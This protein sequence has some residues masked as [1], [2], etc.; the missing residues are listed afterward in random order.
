MVPAGNGRAPQ[1]VDVA[2]VGA[3]LAGLAAARELEAA[4][5]SV[6]V[7]EARDRVGGR[8]LN[9]PIGDGDVVEVGGQWAGPTQD[10]ILALARAVGVET[11]PTHTR[12][13]N[14]I[15]L[16]GELRRYTGTIPRVG[17]RALADVAQ[18]QL[19]ID[20]LARRVPVD[21]PWRTRSAAR[22]DAQTF[23]SWMR[24]NVYT[25]VGRELIRLAVEAVWAAEPEDVSLL[26]VLF[27][28]RS[29]GGF[30]RLLDTEGGAQQDRFVGG[31][32]AIATRTAD[33]I[34]GPVLLSSPVRRIEHGAGS[35]RVLADGGV[36]V[37]ARRAIV[38]IPPALCPR[39]DYDPPLPGHRDGLTQR[40]P[41]G[42]VVK[43]MAVYEEPFWRTAGLSGQA[44]SVLGPV[45]LAFDNSP[46][47][48]RP[49][50]L[51]GFLEGSRAREL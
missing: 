25:R 45:K 13:E 37:A 21:E 43:C 35:V 51:L 50:A 38:A 10:R 19:K 29:A 6:A 27:Y 17:R 26:H 3:G 49:G 30:D 41:Q 42:S 7:L 23:W 28:V 9:E 31:S 24:R 34:G 14:V 40:M 46:P 47:R 12:G 16:D 15:E 33:S 11:F 18:A 4:G 36:E 22:L 44:T 5:R 2:V 20:L 39:I 1:E 32:Q 8:L 48:G